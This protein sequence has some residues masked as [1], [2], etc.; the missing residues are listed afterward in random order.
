MDVRDRA[1]PSEAASTG[2]G[3]RLTAPAVNIRFTASVVL[4]RDLPF[5]FNEEFRRVG[6]SCFGRFA[7]PPRC[8]WINQTLASG[9][10]MARA[11]MT[12]PRCTVRAKSGTSCCGKV[13]SRRAPH[14]RVPGPCA[15]HAATYWSVRQIVARIQPGGRW[16]LPAAELNMNT[17]ATV[18]PP[19]S[20]T[21]AATL[22]LSLL[23]LIAA[24]FGWVI[25]T[26]RLRSVPIRASTP[27]SMNR[28]GTRHCIPLDGLRIHQ[29]RGADARHSVIGY[30]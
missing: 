26:D 8:A 30:Q 14:R 2:A 27:D 10:T 5:R 3:S 28:W 19:P 22:G 15:G 11:V 24:A 7:S 1:S 20:R 13:S 16:N 29:L 21:E 4:R 23:L 9:T 12:S 18:P 6:D 25:G 17:Y